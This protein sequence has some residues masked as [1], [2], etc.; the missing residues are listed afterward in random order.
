[1]LGDF[2]RMPMNGRCQIIAVFKN[3][4]SQFIVARIYFKKMTPKMLIQNNNL[5]L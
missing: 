2:C 5:E 4:D 1:M 3:Y